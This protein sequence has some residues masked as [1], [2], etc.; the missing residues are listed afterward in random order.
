MESKMYKIYTW[1]AAKLMSF[2][3]NLRLK[4]APRPK[5]IANPYIRVGALIRENDKVLLVP[6]DYEGG[7]LWHLPGGKIDEKDF[8]LVDTLIRELK[9]ELEIDIE[10]DDLVFIC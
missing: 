4:L 2:F 6:H 1:G 7:Q 5:M 8:S 9:E 3:L 10:V